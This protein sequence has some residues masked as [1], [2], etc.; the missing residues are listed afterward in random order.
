MKTK[1]S[2]AFKVF[3][4]MI[5]FAPIFM[6]V[7]ILMIPLKLDLYL[8]LFISFFL[9]LFYAKNIIDKQDL[10]NKLFELE[11][12]IKSNKNENY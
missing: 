6:L 11:E 1:E 5:T 10:E 12:L 7:S 2:I 4:L 8:H 9:A 3:W